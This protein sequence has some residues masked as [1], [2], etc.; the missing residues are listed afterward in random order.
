MA[1]HVRDLADSV[2]APLGAVLEGGYEPEVLAQCVA[3]TLLA[4]GGDEPATSAAPDA[5]FTSRAAAR[6]GHY[7]QL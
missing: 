6:V 2:K 5:L 4:L 3:Q 1:R 7:W